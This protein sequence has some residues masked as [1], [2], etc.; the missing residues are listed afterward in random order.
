MLT[1][2]KRKG[3]AEKEGNKSRRRERKAA[4][5]RM[6]QIIGRKE[7]INKN[8]KGRPLLNKGLT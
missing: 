2:L 1:R 3:G 6:Y 5:I 8:G 4:V 7:T